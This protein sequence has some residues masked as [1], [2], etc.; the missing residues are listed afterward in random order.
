MCPSVAFHAASV[1]G[2]SAT[3]FAEPPANLHTWLAVDPTSSSFY[4]HGIFQQSGKEAHSLPPAFG[5]LLVSCIDSLRYQG[6]LLE[7]VFRGAKHIVKEGGKCILWTPLTNDDAQE[8]RRGPKLRDEVDTRLPLIVAEDDPEGAVIAEALGRVAL[9]PSQ[10]ADSTLLPDEQIEDEA[11]GDDRGRIALPEL[12]S[13]VIIPLAW[14]SYFRH[15]ESHVVE[16]SGFE[17]E[18]AAGSGKFSLLVMVFE[19]DHV[20]SDDDVDLTV[21]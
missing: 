2:P 17:K 11:N 16:C 18:G 5:C 13:E 7:C 14:R 19:R 4:G 8:W 1:N 12:V 9:S 15:L 21:F 20:D 3:T 6:T 10:M